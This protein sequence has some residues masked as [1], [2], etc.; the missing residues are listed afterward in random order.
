MK[1]MLDHRIG[2]HFKLLKHSEIRFSLKLNAANHIFYF[3][4]IEPSFNERI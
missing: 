1:K 3:A 2:Q 4:R